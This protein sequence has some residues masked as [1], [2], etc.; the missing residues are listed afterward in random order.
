M[1]FTDVITCTSVQASTNDLNQVGAM[2]GLTDDCG[3]EPEGLGIIE[4]RDSLSCIQW[5]LWSAVTVMV[6]STLGGMVIEVISVSCSLGVLV[7]DPLRH[8][9][10][11]CSLVEHLS[12]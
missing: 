10:S 1:T 12:W 7:P 3:W 4:Y 5:G 8:S 2:S 9:G 11:Y 6:C